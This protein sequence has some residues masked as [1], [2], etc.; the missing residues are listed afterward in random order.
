MSDDGPLPAWF[1][2]EVE[3]A[4]ARLGWTLCAWEGRVAC[5]R[6]HRERESRFGMDNLLRRA[7]GWEPEGR[8]EKLAAHLRGTNNVTPP[9]NLPAVRERLLVR[10]REPFCKD[11]VEGSVWAAPLPGTGLI[12]VLVVDFPE[13]MNYVTHDMI[14]G[15]GRTGEE[16]LAFAVDNLRAITGPEMVSTL[17]DCPGLYSCGTGDAYDASRALALE[18]LWG[19]AAPLGFLVGIPTRDILLFYPVDEEA[20][21]RRFGDLLISTIKWHDEEPYP[22]SDRLYWVREGQWE[23]ITWEHQDGGLTASLPCELRELLQE[24]E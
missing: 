10:L 20:L 9:T 21:D 22:I 6:D 7:Q 5:V 3:L 11:S 2:A 15:S 12:Q 4:L 1:I 18:R 19:S 14:E 8:V 23:E 13:A 24:G 17:D 16:W